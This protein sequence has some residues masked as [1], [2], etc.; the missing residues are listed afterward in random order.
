M[1]RGHNSS[2]SESENDDFDGQLF[3]K[4]N[5]QGNLSDSDREDSQLDYSNSE[6]SKKMDAAERKMTTIKT[7]EPKE[8]SKTIKKNCESAKMSRQ[9]KK[10]YLEC[11]EH[12]AHALMAD[13]AGRKVTV[14]KMSERILYKFSQSN[15]DVAQLEY[16]NISFCRRNSHS[17]NNY[18]K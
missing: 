8:K 9:R 14:Q 2:N 12:K 17:A 16:R 3:K 11:L 1:F 5:Y 15:R 7:S 13:I 10:V 18:S 4:V 6:S